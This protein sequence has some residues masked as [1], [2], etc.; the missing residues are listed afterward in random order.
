MTLRKL[1]VIFISYTAILYDKH[2]V[3]IYYGKACNDKTVIPKAS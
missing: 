1:R 2:M 3:S